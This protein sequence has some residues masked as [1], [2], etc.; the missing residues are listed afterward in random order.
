MSLSVTTRSEIAQLLT[1]TVREK[2]RKYQP[3]TVHM[4]FH[5]RLLG[6]DRY[7]MFSFIQSLNTTFG[8]SVCRCLL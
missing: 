1:T 8:I 2:L 5:H 3:E 6:R 7:A 4:P